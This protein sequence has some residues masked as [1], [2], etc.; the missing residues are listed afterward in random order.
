MTIS[1]V[2]SERVQIE[3][4]VREILADFGHAPGRQGRR[5]GAPKSAPSTTKGKGNKP[6]DSSELVVEGS[7]VS[8]ADLDARLGGVRRVVVSSKAVVT[9]SVVDELRRRNVTLVRKETELAA[10]GISVRLA[11]VVTDR[12]VDL[13]GLVRA[14][15]SQT[16]I[17]LDHER[18]GCLIEATDHLAQ[19]LT[20]TETLGLLLSEHVAAGLS[21]ANRHGN[22]R[23]VTAG[24]LSGMVTAAESVGANLL[25]LDPKKH[26][27]AQLKRIISEYCRGGQRACPDVLRGRLEA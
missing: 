3:R 18:I 26:G 21:L 12:E 16:T 6:S 9:P 7:V 13:T 25:V 14:M 15:A 1:L 8:L 5:P 4:I 20:E 17:N 10:A 24:D 27:L 22:V 11:L 19:K 2:Q 23:A